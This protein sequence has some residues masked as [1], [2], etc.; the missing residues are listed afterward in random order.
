MV[1]NIGIVSK[2]LSPGTASVGELPD[3]D[4]LIPFYQSTVVIRGIFKVN[5]TLPASC[6]VTYRLYKNSSVNLPF[7][8]AVLN[9]G[10]SSVIISNISETFTT[11]DALVVRLAVTGATVG[12]GNLLYCDVGVY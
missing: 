10:T 4:F 2:S 3:I 11:S 5:V 7:M 9:S 1:G 6:V 12:T 8:T